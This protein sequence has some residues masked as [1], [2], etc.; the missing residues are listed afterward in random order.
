MR[1]LKKIKFELTIFHDTYSYK[2]S[3]LIFHMVKRLER[4]E[5]D[6]EKFLDEKNEEVNPLP[7]DE[8]SSIRLGIGKEWNSQR[9]HE[10]I[11]ECIP[12]TS[13]LYLEVNAYCVGTPTNND[14]GFPVQ[15]YKI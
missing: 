5:W 3:E 4:I 7:I 14:N 6:G 13:K 8:P 11:N 15:F 2:A 12:K 10:Y 1:E 9:V